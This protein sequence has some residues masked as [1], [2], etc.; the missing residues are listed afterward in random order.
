[1]PQFPHVGPGSGAVGRR[2]LGG[3]ATHQRHPF[4][5]QFQVGCPGVPCRMPAAVWCWAL[6]VLAGV[7]APPPCRIDAANRTGLCRGQDLAL[8][9]PG[10]PAALRHLDLSYNRLREVA[11]GAFAGLTQLR[12]LDLA[13]NSISRIAPDAFLSN[14]LL[15]H[16][17]LFNN[18]LGSIPAPALRPL[19]NLRWLD[20]SNN[21][22]RSA[23]LDGA[24]RGLR[25]LRELSL[26]G[27]LLQDI[28]RGDF[29]VLKDTAL[30]KFAIK[31]ASGLRRY[32]AGAFSWLNTTELWCDVALDGSAAALPVMLRDL[33][34]KPLD[35]LRFRNLFEFTYYTGDADP[36]AGLAELQITKL[37]FYRGKF[38]ENLLRLALLNVQRSRICE[39]ALVAIDFARSPWQNGSSAGATA[40]RLNRLVLQ[41][42]SNPD[43]LR[44]DWT[45]TWLSGV[46]ALSIINVNFN[47]VPCDVWGELRNVK[48]LDIS[49]NRLRDSYI[50]N[51]LCH[52]Q[53]VM[54]KLENFILASNQL[55]SLAVVATL[56]RTWPRLNRLDASH[57]SL[58]SLQETC[59][60]SP[61]LRWL[62]LHHNQVTVDTFRCLPTTLEYLDLSYSQLDRLDMDYFSQSPRLRELRLSG[63]KI[64]FIPSEWRCLR[65]EV[66][67]IDGNSFG[68][69]NRGSFVNMPRLVSLAAGNNP[70]HCTCD[71]YLFL[72]ETRRWGRPTLADWPHNWTCY[73]PEP[74]LDMAVATYTPRPLECNVPALVTVAVASTAVVVVVCAVLCWKLDAGW[75]LRATYRLVRAR[76]GKRPAGTA[77]R[78]SYHAFI[79]YSRADAGWVRQELLQRLENIVPPYRLCI[80]ERDFTPGR[81]IIENIVENIE[82]SAKVIFIL[83]RSFVDSEWCNYE[84]YFAH[85]RA[86]G[87]GSE[88]VILVVLEPMEARGLPRRFARLRA[89]LATRTYLEWPREPQRRPFFWL[90]LRGLLG[91]PGGLEPAAGEEVAVGAT[92]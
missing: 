24:F 39:L 73:H 89:L 88:D 76:Y 70:Y 64:K 59:Q 56:T 68:I 87:L 46:A 47:Y 41:D 43:I 78:C 63:N 92:T 5:G 18:S 11:A 10:L 34:G 74:L 54:P 81:W 3:A 86:V 40:P 79:S 80:H 4:L 33:R 21:P 1:M 38:S 65:L 31:S 58:G 20:M 16:L 45:F 48:T 32:E 27:P 49:G 60:W 42:I 82:R 26:G 61:T 50:Y 17:R 52:Y 14:L 44:F 91:S 9:P 2:C 66:L 35:Y 69:I 90:Q 12:H 28:S 29:A 37:V 67:A 13:Y 71:L 6:L 62:A 30:R 7:A 15:E 36:F 83:S 53:G 22:Y 8:V 77:R 51:Q 84:L 72:E 75:Y 25:A 85:Q 23:A 55:L 19:A 57:N